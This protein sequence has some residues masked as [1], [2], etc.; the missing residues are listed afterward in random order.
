MKLLYT[1]LALTLV[2]GISAKAQQ[3]RDTI[4]PATDAK[5]VGARKEMMAELGLTKKQAA[6]F[7]EVNKEFAPKIKALRTDSTLDKKARRQQ[8]MDLMK[9]RDDKLK[10]FLTPEQVTKMHDLQQEQ[11]KNRRKGGKDEMEENSN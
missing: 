6:Q 4:R 10:T 3:A 1:L 9:Q 11:M 2:T 8:L 5:T 7:K